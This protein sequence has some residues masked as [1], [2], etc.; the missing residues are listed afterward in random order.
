M[1]RDC[2]NESGCCN[3][4]AIV[5]ELP[6]SAELRGITSMLLVRPETRARRP[7]TSPFDSLQQVT[8]ERTEQKVGY[9]NDT[10]KSI[11]CEGLQIWRAPRSSIDLET[12]KSK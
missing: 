2:D 4:D 10:N 5:K 11:I 3:V 8:V 6:V 12:S 1:N 9:L 7:T